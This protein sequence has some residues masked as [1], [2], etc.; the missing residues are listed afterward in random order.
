MDRP[1]RDEHCR[2]AIIG[3]GPGGIALALLLDAA[4]ID[5]FVVLE[6]ADGIGGTWRCSTYP[7]AECDVPSHLYSYS[8]A[9]NPDWSKT[10]AGQPEILRYLEDCVDRA[11]LRDHFRCSTAVEHVRWDGA[12]TGWRVQPSGGSPIVA[13]LVVSAVGMFNA[14]NIPDLA[15]LADFRG[16]VMHSARWEDGVVLDGRRVA[17][18][19]TGASAI[20]IVPAVAPR[21]EHLTV[22][23]RSPAWI[24]PRVD[25]PYSADDKQRFRSEPRSAEQHRREI[26]EFYESNTITRVD[27]PRMAVL[28]SYARRHL[29]DSVAD[30][31]LRAELLPDYPIGCK[32]ILV[33]NEFYPAL[34]RDDVT[35]VT[36]PIER[37]TPSGIL[38]RDGR[39]HPLD[40]IV[41]ATGYRAVDYLHGLEVEGSGGQDL[42]ALWD[43]EPRAYLGMAVPGFPN[44]FMFYG[45]NTNQSGN[46]ILLVLEAE[47]RYVVE[48]LQA[49]DRE[50]IATVEVKRSAF[51][52]YNAE[53]DADL[54]GS[55]WLAGCHNYFRT[56]RGHVATQLPHPSSWYVD[57]T[58]HVDL[59]DYEVASR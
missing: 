22:F 49:M 14:P 20:Q 54:E 2:V 1:P 41:L 4:G 5:D 19:G 23:Q 33:S 21:T 8:F 31:E 48:V 26:Y 45:P 10:F 55:V 15:G 12:T 46:S 32:R 13:D 37:V 7:G 28:E 40:V 44:F 52:R 16:D 39:E 53:L 35:L 50:R 58:R 11:G 56:P 36:S 9:P 6:K 59:D 17:V 18:I 38:T 47:A 43:G 34:Q 42:H 3:A 57:R 29:E 27:D 24:M 25:K 30:P 51:D